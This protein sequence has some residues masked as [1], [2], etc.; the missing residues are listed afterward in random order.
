MADM[1]L[2]QALARAAEDWIGTPFRHQASRRQVGCDC[3]GLV[4][5]VWRDVLGAE[6]CDIEPYA[7]DSTE[8]GSRNLLQLRVSEVCAE[9]AFAEAHPG[10]LLLFRMRARGPAQHLGILTTDDTFV[11]AYA[12]HGVVR[13]EL[14]SH[15]R[16]KVVGAFEI[17]SE[18]A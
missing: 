13:S 9:V 3:L 15:W 14:T 8:I 4:R 6:P 2:R 12:R 1:L 17:P 10:N 5:G 11:H 18:V 16:R 7:E